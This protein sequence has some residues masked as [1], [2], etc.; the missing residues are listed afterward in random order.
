V[1]RE[2]SDWRLIGVSESD[3]KLQQ[4]LRSA[5][6]PLMKR[7]ELLAHPDVEVVTVESAVRDHARDGLAVLRA[8]KHLHLE[9]AP[10][11]NMADFRQIVELA[12]A[13]ARLVQVGYM[14]RYHPGIEKMLEAARQG[15]L[16]DVYLVKGTI[17]NQLARDRRPEWAEFAGGVMFE[18]G[19]HV[20]DPLIRLKGKPVK[21]TPYLQTG[22]DSLR[23]NTA[24]VFE[25][26]NALGMVQSA[27]VQPG[28]SR[29]RSVEFHGTNGTAVLRPIEPPELQV[30]LENR[31][32]P[33]QAGIQKVALPPYRRYVDD[34]IEFAAALRGE[35]KLRVTAAEDLAV[36]EA[37]LMASG[38]WK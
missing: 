13:K 7:E 37:I 8:G 11:T 35:K 10:A 27:A 26:K 36:H 3:P 6:I 14:W 20:I 31:A 25:W 2:S 38:M 23:D 5:S 33:Y 29:Y 12:A 24:A 18:L 15:W 4:E 21:I 22:A 16:G 9:K 17:G 32:G 19:G 34:F 1:V 30:F 28:S